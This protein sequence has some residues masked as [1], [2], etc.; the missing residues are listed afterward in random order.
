MNKIYIYKCKGSLK[1]TYI[2]NMCLKCVCV[3]VY[4]T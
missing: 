1:H 3:N 4:K 2:F